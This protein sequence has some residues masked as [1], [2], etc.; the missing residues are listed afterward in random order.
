MPIQ[1]IDEPREVLYPDCHHSIARVRDHVDA[2]PSLLDRELRYEAPAGFR[3]GLLQ[4]SQV[5]P[6]W[7]TSCPL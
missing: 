6:L 7:D 2:V 4:S 5:G 1:E 3:Q